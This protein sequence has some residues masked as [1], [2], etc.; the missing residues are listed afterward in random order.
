MCASSAWVQGQS[1]AAGAVV[2]YNGALYIAKFANPGY[3]PTISTYYWAPYSY[4]VWVQGRQYYAGN[5]VSYGGRLY[6]AK[7]D[8]PGY[9]PTISTY[10]WSAC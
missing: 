1:Y 2:T 9:N 6:V 5:V 7:Y 10:Y 3:N 4:P 8:N